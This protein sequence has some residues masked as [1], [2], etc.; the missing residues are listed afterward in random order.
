MGKGNWRRGAVDNQ[1]R[2]TTVDLNNIG[3]KD[4]LFVLSK[5]VNQVFYVKDI[6]QNQREGKTTTTQ[7]MSQSAT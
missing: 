4:E 6:L 1:Y 2:M 5:D 3:Y 7:S